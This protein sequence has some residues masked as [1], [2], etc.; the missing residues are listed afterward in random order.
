M[1]SMTGYGRGEADCGGVKLSVELN[2]LNRK[3]SE[4]VLNL[5][6]DLAQLETRICRAINARISR[7]R[8]NVLITH[9]ATADGVR[10]L[11]HDVKLARS[12]HDAMR[13]LKKELG[14]PGQIRTDTIMQAPRW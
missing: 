3:Q 10:D 11:A 8:T 14:S 2:T 4:I 1:R 13:A 7:G 9:H 12:Y 5:R 6:R